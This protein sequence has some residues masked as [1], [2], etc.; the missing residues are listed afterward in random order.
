MGLPWFVI[1]AALAV[2]VAGAIWSWRRAQAA[3]VRPSA[4]PLRLAFGV[5]VV[6]IILTVIG[7]VYSVIEAAFFDVVS[8]TVPVQ[9]FR[10]ALDP[11]ITE[12]YDRQAEF[13]PSSPGFTEG[14]FGI[15][16]LDPAA[17]A[18]LAVGHAVTG[19][20][21]VV[22]LVLVARLALHAM[23][24]EPFAQPL[25]HLLARSG[26][27]LAVGTVLAQIALGIGGSL[28][29]EQVFR[30]GGSAAEGEFLPGY[31]LQGLDYS[32]LPV[33]TLSAEVQFWPIGVGLA[34]IM[35]GGIM[36]KGERLQRDSAGLV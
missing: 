25:S 13:T 28:A 27:V 20:L 17:R 24:D 19:A 11:A 2:G 31:E 4:A 34:L 12:V 10:P 1:V 36:R 5:T 8:V 29:S 33:S 3:S 14:V 26:A 21:I 22:I 30:I 6:A 9:G 7:T 32:G 15:T 23:Q 16:G 35:V 18:W